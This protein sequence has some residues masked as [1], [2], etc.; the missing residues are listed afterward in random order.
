MITGGDIQ[1]TGT[2]RGG[3]IVLR[4]PKW[5]DFDDW[6]RMRELSTDALRRW[7]PDWDPAPHDRKTF[8]KRLNA[9]R[10]LTTAGTAYPFHIFAD[11]VLVGACNLSDIRP[12]S[13]SSA[14]IGYW[15]GTPHHRRGYGQAAVEAV[16]RFAFGHLGLHRVEAA[17]QDDNI[18]SIRLLEGL[19]FTREG[20]A[21]G[22]L[23]ID[24]AWRDHARYA[25]LSSD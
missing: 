19:G 3:P 1:L 7:E 9:Y 14:Q 8:K 5:S 12:G 10:R 16:L 24:G 21:R 25:R 18:A 13:A 20:V 4:H 17:V 15:I 22:L 2:S 6:A 23:K 11:N